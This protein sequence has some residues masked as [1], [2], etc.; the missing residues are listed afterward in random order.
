MER[1]LCKEK[2]VCGEHDCASVEFVG[3]CQVCGAVE[4]Q[5]DYAGH[6][7]CANIAGKKEIDEDQISLFEDEK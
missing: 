3:G 6:V 5:T 1:Y 4:W 2:G 7:F